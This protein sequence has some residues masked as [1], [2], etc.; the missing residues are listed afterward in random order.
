MFSWVFGQRMMQKQLMITSAVPF[1]V[2]KTGS[3]RAGAVLPNERYVV[4][5]A[6]KNNTNKN[7]SVTLKMKVRHSDGKFEQTQLRLPIV[8]KAKK[9]ALATLGPVRA[10]SKPGMEHMV[11]DLI[12]VKAT[13]ERVD[14]FRINYP[15]NK[16]I[17]RA[18][19]P[20]EISS[21]TFR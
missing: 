15:V 7:F 4:N 1:K 16:P 17:R 12:V 19:E 11:I 3:V 8:L 18:K 6:V 5:V 2:T 14:Q 13:P 10:G 20:L 21:F 9:T